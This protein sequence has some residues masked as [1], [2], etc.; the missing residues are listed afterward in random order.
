VVIVEP[1][2]VVRSKSPVL[3]LN[4]APVIDSP[5]PPPV[6]SVKLAVKVLPSFC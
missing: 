5:E 1:E 4:V 6:L 2:F 3:V